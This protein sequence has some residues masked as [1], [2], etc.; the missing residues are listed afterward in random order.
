MPSFFQNPFALSIE[1]DQKLR[2]YHDG[3]IV[4]NPADISH[5]EL[6]NGCVSQVKQK[7]GAL[8]AIDKNALIGFA[9][10]TAAFGLSY[11]LPLGVVAIAG[12]AYGAYQL[13]LRERAN[14]EYKSALANLIRCCQWSLGEVTNTAVIN[15]AAVKNMI[16]TLAPLTNEAQLREYIDDQY[17]D[18]FVKEADDS[19]KH[20]SVM[21]YPL[22]QEEATLYYKIYGH[23]QGGALAILQGLKYAIINGFHALKQSIQSRG[24]TAPT[25]VV[26]DMEPHA[27]RHTL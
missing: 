20:T 21:D 27:A 8:Q 25:A 3:K 15:S 13:G 22:N 17:E 26:E 19:R 18:I 14:I 16:T 23:E 6:L 12:F 7:L 10:G 5:T 4:Y 2:S 24:K 1:Q 9:L 11:I